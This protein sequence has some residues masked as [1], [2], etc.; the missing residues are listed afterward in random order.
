MEHN[1]VLDYMHRG[2]SVLPCR[3]K[4][5]ATAHGYKDA[6]RNPDDIARLFADS[7]NIGIATG[8]VSGIFVLDVDVKNGAGGDKTL[9]GLEAKHG[10]L[11]QTVSASTWSGG[12]HFYFRYPAGG[13][14][15]KTGFLPGLDIRGDGGY[16][17]A[18][19]SKLSEKSYAWEQGRSPVET[20]IMD[21]PKWLLD[22]LQPEKKTKPHNANL[23]AE[24]RNSTLTKLAGRMRAAGMDAEGIWTELSKI[25]AE[26]CTPPLPDKEVRTIAESIGKYSAGVVKEPLTDVWN[27][28]RLAERYGDNVRWCEKLGGWHY[29]DGTCWRQN[30]ETLLMRWAK[31]LVKSWQTQAA[32][33]DDRDLMRHAVR[34]ESN[35]RLNAMVSLVKSEPNILAPFERFDRDYY[36]LNCAN[37][38]LDLETGRLRDFDRADMITRKLDVAYKPD[39]DCPTWKAFLN[40]IFMGDTELITYLQ[41][42]VGYCLSGDTRE[43]KFFLCWGNGRNGKSTL[44]K[45]I[46][47]ILAPGYASGT[48]AA[49]MLESESQNALNAIAA[50]KGMR[51]V[52][53][54]EFDEGK[55]MSAAQVK[56]L[57]GG[58]PVVA[59]FLYCSQFTYTPTY[60][61]WMST[62]FKPRIKDTSLGIWRRL[63]LIPFEYTVPVE[64]LD[65][66]LDEKLAAEY[67]GI[68]AWAVQGFKIWK[69][70]GLSAI[71]KLSA[72]VEAYQED[73]DVIGQFIT[74][75][76][77]PELEPQETSVAN[78]MQGLDEWCKE[79]GIRFTPSRNMV[80]DY[81]EKHGYGRPV[82][83]SSRM[84][85]SR[86][87]W[88][89][90]A[91]Q[92][93]E[94]GRW[95]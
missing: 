86:L 44:L 90:I 20:Q 80:L 54:N 46:M 18:P 91:I 24:N 1:I 50:L 81:M 4:L 5:P 35:A 77:D 10:A 49:T 95:F 62:N 52:I 6:T 9:A 65:P 71:K 58:E 28:E 22:I 85:R 92:K 63:V 74:E 75:C 41:K 47:Y 23:I 39:A 8:A 56:N 26:R 66:E 31:D 88:R 53:L 40:D 82:M 27:C 59:R 42:A 45:H 12:R 21:A 14:G 78:L 11:P 69:Q 57:T 73:S 61:F 84:T 94:N 32:A 76:S 30:D 72:V 16:V 3:G 29:W 17:V 60:K 25:N 34:C 37:G 48:P 7:N 70:D 19:P 55:T 2:W 79:N 51:Y 33:S 87:I 89:G 64:K 83:G 43:Q 67:E 68:L 93:K 13:V 36:L 15:C 38:T